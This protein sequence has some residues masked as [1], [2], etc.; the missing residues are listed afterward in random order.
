[1][2]TKGGRIS[3]QGNENVLNLTIVINVQ[4]FEIKETEL[5]ILKKRIAY[6]NNSPIK[7]FIKKKMCW[8]KLPK[9]ETENKIKFEMSYHLRKK[10]I[11]NIYV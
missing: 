6:I 1:M 7:L 11:G 4:F 9:F 2:T 3:F 5:C 10:Y 8:R